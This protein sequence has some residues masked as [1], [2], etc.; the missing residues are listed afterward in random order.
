MKVFLWEKRVKKGYSVREL[1]EISGI[2]KS[3]ISRIENNKVSPTIETVETLADAL[4]C[5]FFEMFEK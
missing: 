3:T 4:E 2:S 5:T 1:S